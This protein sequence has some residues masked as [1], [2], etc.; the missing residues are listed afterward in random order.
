M[1]HVIVLDPS[2]VRIVSN[3][4]TAVALSRFSDLLMFTFVLF[5]EHGLTVTLALTLTLTLILNLTFTLTQ[6]LTLTLALTLSLTLHLTQTLTRNLTLHR[7][8][9]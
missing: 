9:T 8:Q 2:P 7:T 1:S 5:F 4:L 6:T 3:L